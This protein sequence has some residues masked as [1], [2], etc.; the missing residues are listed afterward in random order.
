MAFVRSVIVTGVGGGVGQSIAKC[1]QRGAYLAVGVDADEVATGLYGMQRGYRGLQATGPDFIANLL[2]ICRSESAPVL[3]PGLDSELRILADNRS[4]FETMGTTVVVSSPDV[5][6]LC[7]DKLATATFLQEAGLAHPLTLDVPPEPDDDLFPFVLKPRRGGSRSI[8]VF[9]CHTRR[10]FEHALPGIDPSN[11]V[12]QEYLP[13]PEY[14]CGTVNWDGACHGVIVMRRTLRSGDTYK[15]FVERH[16]A[17][18]AYVSKAA[19]ALGPFGACNFQL[20]LR[21]GEPC[22]FEINAR[23]SGTTHA[24]A[25]AGFNEP[26]LILDRLLNHVTKP[27]I[28]VDEIAV[29]RYW[30]ELAV[31]PSQLDEVKRNGVTTCPSTHL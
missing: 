7:D 17:I 22:V 13:G 29:F 20:R 8:G 3:F 1:L 2:Q 27:T 16:E 15:A 14:T 25:L 23:C 24:R 31:R 5:I 30:Q 11:Y 10:D 4:S 21:S 26:V 18:E 6:A 19:E 28:S 12:L 9:T